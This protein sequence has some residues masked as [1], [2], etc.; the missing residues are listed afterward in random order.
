VST[1]TGLRRGLR[2]LEALAGAEQAENGGL[3]VVAIARLIG[4]DKSQAS[5]TL[6]T[7]AEEGLV[8]RDPATLGYRLGPR[9]FAYAAVVARGR[10]LRTAPPLLGRLVA[11][12]GERAHL[13]VLDGSSVLTLL[14]ES[15]AHAIQAVGWVGRLVPAWNTASGRAL[16][17]EAGSGELRA[18]LADVSFA[19][20]RP[21][22][23]RDVDELAR[24]IA[25]ARRRGYAAV[26]EEFEPGLVGVAAPVRGFGGSIVAALNVSAPKFRF[27]ERLDEAGAALARAAA[28]LSAELAGTG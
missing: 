26:D 24:R 14:S 22:A 18:R 23:P 2:V 27:G 11:L 25:E 9:I 28:E 16:L 5:R 17:L 19:D 13:S 10:L 20:G 6:R 4:K 8:E 3:G 21:G 12:L 1:E 7:L 15:P